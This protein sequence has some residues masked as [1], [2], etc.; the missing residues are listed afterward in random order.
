MLSSKPLK[1]L[2]TIGGKSRL[3]PFFISFLRYIIRRDNITGFLDL[4]GGGNI[5]IPQLR[6]FPPLS[7]F[8]Y[9]DVDIG[10]VNLMTSFTEMTTAKATLD[11]AFWLQSEIQTEETFHQARERRLSN[12]TPTVES[13]AL[14]ILIAEFSRAADRQTFCKENA[15]QG[16]SYRSLMR[17]LEFVPFLQGITIK[18]GSYDFFIRKFGHRSDFLTLL[19]PPYVGADCYE[20]PFPDSE[21][22]KMLQLINEVDMKIVLCGTDNDIYD[23]LMEPRWHKTPLG[24]IPKSS[25]SSKGEVQVEYI[26]TNFI[27]PDFLLHSRWRYIHMP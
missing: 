14:T 9:N 4:F 1:K 2:P 19:D 7:K 5:F 21:Q 15:R 3:L 16:I 17:Y 20:S 8:I 12:V 25:S 27:V 18:C 22:E 11:M 26:W 10:I 6:Y 23:Y 24:P 13:A